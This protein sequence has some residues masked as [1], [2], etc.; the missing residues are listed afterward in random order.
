MVKNDLIKIR[1]QSRCKQ[2]YIELGYIENNGYF[3]VK[4]DDLP[5][6]SGVQETRICDFCGEEFTRRHEHHVTT[7][8]RFGKDICGQCVENNEQVQKAILDKRVSTTK[9]RYGGMGFASPVIA[10]KIKEINNEKYGGHPMQNAQVKGKFLTTMQERYGGNS[11]QCD[12]IVRQKTTNSLYQ[13]GS[14]P[15]SSQQ[16]EIFLQITKLFPQAN[17]CELNYPCS[18][19]ALD[20][21][22]EID[23]VKLDI[24]YDGEYWHQDEQRDRRRDEVVKSLGFKILRIKSKRNIPTSEQLIEKITTLLT[25]DKSFLELKL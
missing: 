16:N 19:L 14:A 9:K 22:L 1:S 4:P 15:I 6:H 20:I 13:N 8:K 21:M 18:S 2:R 17:K 23:G 11:P 12:P 24:E 25:T 5:E 3:Y 10:Q 7:F